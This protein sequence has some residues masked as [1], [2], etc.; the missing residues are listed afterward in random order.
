MCCPCY[1]PKYAQAG[2][3]LCLLT[4]GHISAYNMDNT[5]PVFVVVRVSHPLCFLCCWVFFAF[6]LYTQC[7]SGLSSLD[8]PLSF[9]SRLF[10]FIS[11]V[12]NIC[13]IYNKSSSILNSYC[14]NIY[15]I[16]WSCPGNMPKYYP[17]L[18][19]I[20]PSPDR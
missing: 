9:L 5:I 11:C 12:W 19:D 10:R 16:M 1:M 8:C 14:K 18:R 17:G 7:F 20:L 2:R 4:L 3:A 13:T 15:I 6:V